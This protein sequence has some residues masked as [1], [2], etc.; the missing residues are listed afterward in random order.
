ML[1][2][3]VSLLFKNVA[4]RFF[5]EALMAILRRIS[6]AEVTE[7]LMMRLIKKFLRKMAAMTENTV[8]DKLVEDIIASLE[9]RSLPKVEE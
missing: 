5:V 4:S 1:T 9:S 2:N 3:I 7:R 6:W 8:D